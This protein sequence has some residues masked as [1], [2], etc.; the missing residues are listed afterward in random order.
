MMVAAYQQSIL[1]WDDA[2]TKAAMLTFGHSRRTVGDLEKFVDA[3]D[4]AEKRLT[5]TFEQGKE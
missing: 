4:P 5:Q 2:Q 1:G 3:Y